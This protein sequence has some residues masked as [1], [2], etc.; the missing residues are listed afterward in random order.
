GYANIGGL[1]MTSGIPYDSKEGRAIA[2]AITAV[3][4]GIAYKTSAEMAGEL[5][6][7]PD[8]ARNAPHMLRVMRNHRNAA[9]G[10]AEGYEALSVNPV[11]L[12]HASLK[13][14]PLAA[15]AKT[16]WDEALALG[17]Q[18]G[19]RNAQVSVIAPTGTIGLVMDCDTTGIEPDFALVKFKKLA[20][21][22][23]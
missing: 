16:A 23:Y 17:E 5:G 12:D 13:D 18:H 3:M 19:F 1:L 7:F 6:A 15:R 2:G 11:P 20:G 14:A 9:H 4:T 8:Y 21:G 22:G 10:N